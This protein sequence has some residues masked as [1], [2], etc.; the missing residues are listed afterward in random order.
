[1]GKKVLLVGWHPSAVNYSK[2]PGLTPEKLEAGLRADEAKLNN[3]GFEAELAFIHSSETAVSD[4]TR[5]LNTKSYDVVL[6]GAGV[7]RDDD[8]FLV[9]ERPVNAVHE[10]APGARIAFNTGPT[11]SDATVLRWA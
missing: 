1:M 9:F 3:L 8:H 7:R 6:I 10:L 11:D 2:W 5:A 4:V